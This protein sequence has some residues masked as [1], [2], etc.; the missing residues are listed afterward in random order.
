MKNAKQKLIN[1]I[2]I[3]KKAKL[4]NIIDPQNYIRKLETEFLQTSQSLKKS[5]TDAFISDLM[6]F[7]RNNTFIMETKS[8]QI[9]DLKGKKIILK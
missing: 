3:F 2:K 4:D 5:Q 6:D 8:K 1:Q 7:K 9:L